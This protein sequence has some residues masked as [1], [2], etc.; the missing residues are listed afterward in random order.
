MQNYCMIIFF[1]FLSGIIVR[2]YTVVSNFTRSSRYQKK[3]LD[4]LPISG[5]PWWHKLP[6]MCIYMIMIFCHMRLIP[7]SALIVSDYQK[8]DFFTPPERVYILKRERDNNQ[9]RR[10]KSKKK[11]QKRDHLCVKNL[12]CRNIVANSQSFVKSKFS[13]VLLACE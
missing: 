9:K 11:I 2:N 13:M 3:L 10:E 5:G 6:T 8:N 12:M 4:H 7:K 1:F